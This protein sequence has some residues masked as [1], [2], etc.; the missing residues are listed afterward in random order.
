[1]LSGYNQLMVKA[2]KLLSLLFTATAKDTYLIFSSNIFSSFLAF[3]YTIFLARVFSPEKLGIFT[4]VTA[5]VLLSSDVLD[6]GISTSLSRFYPELQ[7]KVGQRDSLKFVFNTFKFKITVSI[8]AILIIM[9]LSTF[10][11]KTFLNTIEYGNLFVIAGIGTLAAS[12]T[13]FSLAYLSAQKRFIPVSIISGFSTLVKLFLLASLYYLGLFSVTLVVL[14]FA[15]APFFAFL[16]SLKFIKL[17]M[18]IFPIDFKLVK[19]LMSYSAFIGLSRIF[20]AISSRFDALMLIPLSSAFEA[21]IYSAA[22]KIAFT[23][24]LLSGSFSMV[25]APRLSS[26]AGKK[27]A[28]IYTKKIVLGVL[29]IL[30]SVILM[31]FIAPVFVPFVLGNNYIE[32]VAVFRAL[33]FPVAIFVATIPSVNFL[34]Y[35]VKKPEVSAFNTFIQIFIIFFANYYF[36][37]L[38]G[39]FGPVYTLSLAYGYNLLSSLLFSFYYYKNA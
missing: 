5:F 39:R 16:L 23:Y 3:L 28:L 10:F 35:V 27:E 22:Y 24:I 38:Y 18:A 21:G 26:F 9:L 30:L 2:T 15:V 34:L 14:S 37:P 11:S 6:M 32:S 12:L 17:P 29:L 8:V 4:S 20:S 1:M 36:I 13:S 7:R 31:F 33:L 25:I 19:K